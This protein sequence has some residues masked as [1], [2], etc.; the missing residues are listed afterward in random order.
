MGLCQIGSGIL[1]NSLDIIGSIPPLGMFLHKV[2]GAY[3]VINNISDIG[4]NRLPGPED[5]TF[6]EPAAYLI[7]GL[8]I[9]AFITAAYFAFKFRKPENTGHAVAVRK[10]Y[11]AFAGVCAFT[12]ICLCCM[13]LY[14]LHMWWLTALVSFA[15]AIIMLMI[16]ALVRS[17][18]KSELSKDFVRGVVVIVC[19][20]AFLFVFDKTGAF[21]TRYYNVS[22]EKTESIDIGFRDPHSI[23]RSFESFTL[24]DKDDI[25][26]FIESIN[27]T[28]KNRSD[29]LEYGYDFRITYNLSNQKSIYRDFSNNEMVQSGEEISAVKEM[30]ENVRSL[31]NYP[32]YSSEAAAERISH[33]EGIS[34]VMYDK[35]GEITIPQ[36]HIGKF[37]EI[38]SNE[39]IEKYDKN[40]KE[41]GRVIV[42]YNDNGYSE[43]P[44]Y[45][46]CTDAIGFAESLRVYDGD[47]VAFTIISYHDIP[48][49]VNVK[50]KDVD[51][52]EE[53]ELFS[54][55]EQK[56]IYYDSGFTITADNRL[57]YIVP[58][59]N[60]ERVLELMMTIIEKQFTQPSQ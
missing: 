12:L 13:I 7:Y 55:F 50:V 57:S 48:M 49:T 42:R 51:N 21:G 22:P 6:T 5:M 20:L 10:F 23:S 37:K 24:T 47:A 39:I 40:A 2:K 30:I 32:R 41:A 3:D 11:Y 15:A 27:K 34:I 31:P 14:R 18:K 1:G 59:E 44:I 58:E 17:R 43:F 53:K 35:F 56:P 38:L 54:L 28:L 33:G 4:N 19:C 8:V 29:E 52:A 9:A 16:F 60:K 26:K 36:E 46:S 45:S 25:R